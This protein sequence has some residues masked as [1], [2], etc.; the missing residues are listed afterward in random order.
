MP[1]P[2]RTRAAHAARPR[3]PVVLVHGILGT[4]QLY[5]NLFRARLRRDG[6]DVHEVGL[7]F[8]LLGDIR[9]A[10]SA[11]AVEVDALRKGRRGRIDLVAHSAGGLVARYYVQ[12][13]GGHRHVANLVLLGTPHHGTV[14]SFVAPML[15]VA[16][17]SL[18]GSRLLGEINGKR[19]PPAV[20]VTNF[21]SPF[22]GV[23]LPAENSVLNAP[24][25]RNVRLGAMHHWGFLLSNRV[26]DEVKAVLR[27]GRRRAPSRRAAP[28]APRPDA[29]R[30][31]R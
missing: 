15:K 22:D 7:P 24:G 26:C 20:R 14:T 19:F 11:L 3:R 9:K 8:V 21:W 2:S 18:P 30:R 27:T 16:S 25:V 23:V 29:P 12:L 13:L 6:F 1:R 28:P 10:A 5:W 17:Q 31:R 4:R